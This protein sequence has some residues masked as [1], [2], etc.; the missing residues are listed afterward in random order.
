MLPRARSEKTNL[1]R[2]RLPGPRPILEIFPEA[3]AFEVLGHW[4]EPTTHELRTAVRFFCTDSQGREV[5]QDLFTRVLGSEDFLAFSCLRQLRT[6]IALKGRTL[7]RDDRER[8]DEILRTRTLGA[9]LELEPL[10]DQVD[11]RPAASAPAPPARSFLQWLGFSFR[12]LIGSYR[13]SS[14]NPSTALSRKGTQ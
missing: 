13:I 6:D 7:T 8:V 4:T 12:V 11:D 2:R 9:W 3:V 5:G 14:A 10:I 1:S